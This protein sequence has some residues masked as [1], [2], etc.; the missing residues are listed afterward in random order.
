MSFDYSKVE[1]TDVNTIAI[2]MK[3][4]A[5][6]EKINNKNLPNVRAEYTGE[7]VH[8]S[9]SLTPFHVSCYIICPILHECKEE[10]DNL[11]CPVIIDMLVA[12]VP[13]D[14]TYMILFLDGISGSKD[15]V[16]SKDE[17]ISFYDCL[18]SHK[19]FIR[20]NG[21]YLP[22]PTIKMVMRYPSMREL[23]IQ[24]FLELYRTL[25]QSSQLY[26]QDIIPVNLIGKSG[27]MVTNQTLKQAFEF[28]LTDE[29]I[30]LAESDLSLEECW[31]R[32]PNLHAFDHFK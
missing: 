20:N 2:G 22:I 19:V 31:S 9:V 23:Y 14:K 32:I 8:V 18:I 16:V 1:C 10:I 3:A 28:V 4:S 6:V 7:H 21:A 30:K 17:I 25:Y 5:L 15:M 26:L 27:D 29:E 11:D 24:F 12:A 13:N